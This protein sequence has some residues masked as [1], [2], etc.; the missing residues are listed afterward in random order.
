MTRL[1]AAMARDLDVSPRDLIRATLQAIV[2]AP[3]VL[4]GL[5]AGIALLSAVAG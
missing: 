4:A 2:A 3:F 5:V 1:I